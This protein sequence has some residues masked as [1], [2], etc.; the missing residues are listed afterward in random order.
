VSLNHTQEYI[1]DVLSINNHHFHN[2]IHFIYMYPDKLEIKVTTESDIP[3]LYLDILLNINSNGRL[4]ITLYDKGDSFH[5]AIVNFP[6][7]CS[8]IPLSPAYDVCISQLI[9]YAR[10]CFAYKT[11][12]KRGQLQTKN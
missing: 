1:N 12:S 3:A 2:Y 11:F 5:F 10:A 9:R 7:L 6:F 4:I 8:N